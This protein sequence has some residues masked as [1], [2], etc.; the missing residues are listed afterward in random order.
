MT[1]QSPASSFPQQVIAEVAAA[2]SFTK[3]FRWLGVLAGKG[4]DPAT[5]AEIQATDGGATFDNAT[6]SLEALGGA[7]DAAQIGDWSITRTFQVSG[8]AKVSGVRMSLVGVAGK[9][10]T[11]S[12]NGVATVK[13]NDGTYTLRVVVPAGYEDVAD[14]TVTIDGADDKATVTLVATTVSPPTNP[15][16]SRLDVLCLDASGVAEAGVVVD[17]RIVTVPSG[18]TNTAFRGNKQTATSGVDGIATFEAP[19]GAKYQIKR[20]TAADW[21]T[22]TIGS[23][24]VTTINSF[25]GSP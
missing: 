15:L 11:T 25:I 21:Q 14:T 7:V 13:T 6:M 18:S 20:G 9:T 12:S 4:S 2:S 8:G 3:L 24:D 1:E 5:L 23:G 17:A 22:I 19:R 16:M 10:D